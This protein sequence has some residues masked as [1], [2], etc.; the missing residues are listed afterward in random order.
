MAYSHTPVSLLP[1]YLLTVLTP[2]DHIC[3]L[4]FESVLKKGEK[5]KQHV[6]DKYFLA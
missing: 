1:L 6:E 3:I 4:Y 5:L 2:Q